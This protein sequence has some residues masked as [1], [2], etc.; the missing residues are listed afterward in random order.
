MS[1][2]IRALTE[3]DLPQARRMCH[4]AFGTFLGAPDPD[5][6]WTDRDCVYGR[7]GAEHVASFGVEQEGELIG[8]NF[9]T[10]WGSVGFFGPNSVRPDRQSHGGGK[11]L[12]QAVTDQFDA[13]GVRHAGLCTFPQSPLHIALYGKFGYRARFLTPVMIARR[14]PRA[15]RVV[16]PATANCRKAIGLLSRPP[17]ES[18][19]TCCTTASI[20]VPRFAS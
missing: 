16:G 17:A 7:F 20:S 15:M 3:A 9:A 4:A 1:A 13:W 6:F 10:R 5:N 2:T 14:R 18:S 12:V 19:P 11:A 8:S